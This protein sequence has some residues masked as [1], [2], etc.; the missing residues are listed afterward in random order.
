MD[1]V[2]IAFKLPPRSLNAGKALAYC[3]DVLQAILVRQ[4]PVVYKIGVTG[5][6]LF[7]FYKRPSSISPS[8][9]YFYER[10]RFQSMYILYAAAAWD[11]AALM[12]A[13]LIESHLHKQGC[14]NLQPGGEGRQVYTGPF[15]VY[16]VCKSLK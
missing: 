16:V 14:R 9:G 2:R 5:N 7:R 4:S 10:D 8:P 3:R 15:F 12:E 6:P 11:E 1:D 13:V